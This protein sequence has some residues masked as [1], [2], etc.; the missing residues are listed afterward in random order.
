M[1][2]VPG[3]PRP[4]L[5]AERELLPADL[6][7]VLG[8][9]QLGLQRLLR[10]RRQDG[11]HHQAAAL[12]CACGLRSPQEGPVRQVLIRSRMNLYSSSP[13]WADARLGNPTEPGEPWG[14]PLLCPG[15]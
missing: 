12:R 4:R 10:G 9:H 13:F 15:R 7:P 14:R 3:S 5:G 11:Q 1:M 2:V 6:L 8:D